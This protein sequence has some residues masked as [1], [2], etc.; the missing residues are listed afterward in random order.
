MVKSK[1]DITS[2]WNLFRSSCDKAVDICRG[3]GNVN[4][5]RR[6]VR[7]SQLLGTWNN[8]GSSSG[9]L[10]I[11]EAAYSGYL[12]IVKYLVEEVGVDINATT[13]VSPI[14]QIKIFE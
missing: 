6:L 9:D 14:F 7:R 12:D 10:P 13:S 3:S 2:V 1:N 4:E 11:H 8:S 5:L